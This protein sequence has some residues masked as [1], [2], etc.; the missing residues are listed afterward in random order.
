[1]AVE[2]SQVPEQHCEPLLQER[3]LGLQH[4][5][6]EQMVFSVVLQQSAPLLNAG[7]R[8]PVAA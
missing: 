3:P 1:L 8:R 5:P 7:S 2:V 4:L 6:L